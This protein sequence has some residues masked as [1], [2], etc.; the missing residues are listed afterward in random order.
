MRG[1][2]RS[3][4]GFTL[5]ELLIVVAIIAILAAIA[6]PNFLEAQIRSKVS[7]VKADMRS[8]ATALESYCVDNNAFPMPH[9]YYPLNQWQGFM[10]YLHVLSTPVAYMTSTMVL[11]P[12]YPDTFSTQGGTPGWGGTLPPGWRPT[13]RYFDYQGEAGS[14][15]AGCHPGVQRRGAVINSFGPN[16]TPDGAEH[17]PYFEEYP[18]RWPEGTSGVPGTWG[19]YIDTLYD[20][21][22]GTR[23]SG[24]VGRCVGELRGSVMGQ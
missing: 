4:Y 24:D 23:S 9:L 21:T 11:D 18:D 3:R 10:Q 7:R 15:M 1:F 22:N 2:L 16:M 17:Y 5:I 8:F 13:F 19:S 6:V 12:F 20:P 14:W